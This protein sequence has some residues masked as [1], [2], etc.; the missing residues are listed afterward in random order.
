MKIIVII[1]AFNEQAAIGEVVERSLRYA[2]DVLVIDD[3][4]AD[5]TSEIAERQV[6]LSYNIPLILERVFLCVTLSPRLRVMTLS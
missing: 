5:D 1:P 2:D 3:G 6:H 4:S